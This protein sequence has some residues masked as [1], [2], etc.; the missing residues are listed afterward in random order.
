MNDEKN[1][2][3][4]SE[5][6]VPAEDLSRRKRINRIKKCIIGTVVFVVAVCILSS[7]LLLGRVIV[8]EKQLKSAREETAKWE[9]IARFYGF[10]QSPKEFEIGEGGTIVGATAM[11]DSNPFDM[12][13][14]IENNSHNENDTYYIYLTFDDG[15]GENTEE[16]LKILREYDVKATFFSVGKDDEDSR[17]LYS[18]IIQAGH[19]LGMHSYS[20]KYGEIYK[21]SEA[22]LADLQKIRGLIADETGKV[23]VYYRFP[24]GSSNNV[25]SKEKI[26]QFT[27]ILHTQGIEYIDWNIDSKDASDKK[28][29]AEDIVNNVFKDFGKY[30]NNVVLLHDGSGHSA[31]VEALPLIIE[32][33]RNM[34]AVLVPITENTVP[35]QHLTK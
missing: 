6:S 21:S 20:H 8:L 11:P 31:T 9:E 3:E 2:V 29:T 12:D 24:G 34:G 16:I 23:P 13:S 4:M 10:S 26:L 32:R 18:E 1:I 22:F 30:H 14:L 25:A 28:L 5:S 27:E 35:V 33:A 19:T 15:P 17:R 7:V